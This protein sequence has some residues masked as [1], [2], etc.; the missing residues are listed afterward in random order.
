MSSDLAGQ[1]GKAADL[2]EGR[3]HLMAAACD[4]KVYL[5]G[6]VCIGNTGTVYAYP[7]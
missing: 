6:G 4:G 1:W 5:F 7:P 2:P 3:H